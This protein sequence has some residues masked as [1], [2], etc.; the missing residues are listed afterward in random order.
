MRIL[1]VE[2]EPLLQEAIADGLRI[3]GYAVDT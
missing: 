3:Y 1:V 2:D